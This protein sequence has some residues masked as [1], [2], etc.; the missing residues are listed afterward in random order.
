MPAA[1]QHAARPEQPRSLALVAAVLGGSMAVTPQ[2]EAAIVNITSGFGIGAPNGGV[3]AGSSQAFSGLFGTAESFSIA[4]GDQGNLWGFETP[5]LGPGYVQFLEN[6]SN[7][8]V[9]RIVPANF[10]IDDFGGNPFAG[11]DTYSGYLRNDYVPTN[12]ASFGPGSYF[13]MRV[14]N[15]SDWLYGYLEVTWDSTT[16]EFNILSGAYESTAGV[17]ILAGA[18]AGGGA[19][20]MPGAAGLAACGL[21]GLS[22]RRRR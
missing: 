11:S 16:N 17:G 5:V 21:L 2:S 13:A 12:L 8:N 19:V 14:Y 4:N 15:G 22:R 7:V 1:D 10:M 18:T 6:P 20:P 3:A 9:A